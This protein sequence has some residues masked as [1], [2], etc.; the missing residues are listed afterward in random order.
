MHSIIERNIHLLIHDHLCSS[1][2]DVNA[3]ESLDVVVYSYLSHFCWCSWP[4]TSPFCGFRFC[5]RVI[6][7]VENGRLSSEVS[8]IFWRSENEQLLRFF[9]YRLLYVQY[10]IYKRNS[11]LWVKLLNC[12]Y[13]RYVFVR[14]LPLLVSRIEF[15][16]CSRK[17]ERN[18][19]VLGTPNT[20]QTRPVQRSI[21]R[22]LD[23]SAL[24][25]S[26]YSSIFTHASFTNV[27]WITFRFSIFAICKSL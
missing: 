11:D 23:S 9:C 25:Y 8:V 17:F 5:R 14:A 21:D 2:D 12:G 18:S 19:P 15:C 22:S 26:I 6:H 13:S 3:S 1:S 7:P 24:L 20:S 4:T 16:F 10:K 27:A